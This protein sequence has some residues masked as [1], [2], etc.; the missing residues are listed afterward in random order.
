MNDKD[1]NKFLLKFGMVRTLIGKYL[2]NQS[3]Q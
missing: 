2:F 3:L 1:I